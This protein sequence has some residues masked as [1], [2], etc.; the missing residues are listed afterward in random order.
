MVHLISGGP[1]GLIPSGSQYFSLGAPG[2]ELG[3]VQAIELADLNQD[4]RD[5]L[6]VAGTGG[7]QFRVAVLHGNADGVHPA[8]LPAAGT[9][10]STPSGS[11]RSM[12]PPPSQRHAR[13]PL[14]T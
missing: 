14:G 7:G 5:D 9:R 1:A 12:P 4:G 8:A 13:W 2:L 3:S 11:H 10:G 6:V